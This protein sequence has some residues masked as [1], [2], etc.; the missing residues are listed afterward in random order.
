M[1]RTP[2]VGIVRTPIL[3]TGEKFQTI[4]SHNKDYEP[5]EIMGTY[6]S[7]ETARSHYVQDMNEIKTA[8]KGY[9]HFAIRKVTVNPDK[10]GG[11]S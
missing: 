1:E 5:C 6:S 2:I 4:A 9:L 8:G 10:I 11:K 7:L 3:T